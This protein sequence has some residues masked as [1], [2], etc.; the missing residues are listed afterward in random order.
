MTLGDL[1]GANGWE[2]VGSEPEP[3][4]EA[5]PEAAEKL[6]EPRGEI[7]EVAGG[8]DNRDD[9]SEE[10]QRDSSMLEP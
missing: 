6:I 8:S 9:D 2:F 1:D 7:D 4:A 3:E 5:E 10:G